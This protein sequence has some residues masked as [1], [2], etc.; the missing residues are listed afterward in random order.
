MESTT[1]VGGWD[2]GVKVSPAATVPPGSRRIEAK[3]PGAVVDRWRVR[4]ES[5]P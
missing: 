4:L 2:L 3:P 1:I 5:P